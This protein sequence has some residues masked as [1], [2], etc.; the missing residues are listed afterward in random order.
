MT[1]IS[2]R[3]FVQTTLGLALAGPAVTNAFAGVQA[4]RPLLA[5]SSLGAPKWDFDTILSY[6]AKNRYQ[7]IELRG[8]LDQ[9]D[10]PLC[11]EFSTPEQIKVS[12][13]KLKK[14]RVQVVG[15]GASARLHIADPK[16][17]KENLDEAKRF[18]DL[19]QKIDCPYV[20]VFPN[21]LPKNQDREETIQLIISGLKELGD[22]AKDKKVKV[23]LESHGEVIGK[24]LLKR[25]MQASEHPNVA[26]IWDIFN[27]WS[28]TGESPTEV[29]D[30]LK[31]YIVHVHVKDAVKENG[32]WRYV[33]VGKG[34]APLKEAFSALQKGGYKGFYAFEWEKK[35]HPTIEEPEVV[36]PEFPKA[37]EALL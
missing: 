19:A 16:L 27:M 24:D 29:Y 37:L 26:L 28:V 22:Y 20:R 21:N 18:I 31:K 33:Q 35:W 10:L 12:V 13:A 14:H 5:F 36:I 1:T 3:K 23:L 8:I 15:L 2:R 17:R 32:K 6:A 34:E 9:M 11:P 30:A 25:I 7:G 4:K